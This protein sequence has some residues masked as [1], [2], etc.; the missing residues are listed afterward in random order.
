MKDGLWRT[1]QEI[2]ETL[3]IEVSETSISSSLRDLRKEKF[4][5]HTVIGRRTEGIYEYRL[6]PGA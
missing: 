1:V 6:E 5:G 4:G 2:A 3:S